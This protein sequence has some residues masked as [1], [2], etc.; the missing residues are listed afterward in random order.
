M[1]GRGEEGGERGKREGR[2]NGM[3]GP[4]AGRCHGPA[5]TKDE[6]GKLA[7]AVSNVF[8]LATFSW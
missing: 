6:P 5:L 2:G 3:R 4:Q 7:S 8:I 1:E